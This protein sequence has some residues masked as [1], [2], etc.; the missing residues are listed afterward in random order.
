M[1]L[2]PLCALIATYEPT[3]FDSE[4]HGALP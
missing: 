4:M 2:W 3:R 1:S